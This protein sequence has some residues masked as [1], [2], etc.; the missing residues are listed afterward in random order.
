MLPNAFVT[1]YYASGRHN[2][3]AACTDTGSCFWL[4]YVYPVKV[5]SLDPDIRAP[6][7]FAAYR[8]RRDPAMDAVLE[9]ESARR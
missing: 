1:V 2:Y 9:R 5:D 4:N 3:R 6:I 7:T 8:A